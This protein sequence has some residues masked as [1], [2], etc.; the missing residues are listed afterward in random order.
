MQTTNPIDAALNDEDLRALAGNGSLNAN[1]LHRAR[2]L[3]GIT[4]NAGQWHTFLQ[5]L[6]VVG[7]AAVAS[8]ALICFIAY[9]WNALGRWFRFGLIEGL[10]VIA[11]VVALMAGRRT[12]IAHAA[13]LIAFFALGGLLA[14]TGQTYQTGADTWQL[15]AGWA[16]LGLLW[17]FAARWWGLWLVWLLVV[18]MGLNI[19]AFG[20]ARL[21]RWLTRNDEPA[22]FLCLVNAVIFAAFFW[23]RRFDVLNVPWVWRVAAAFTIFWAT[24]SGCVGAWGERIDPSTAL[25]VLTGAAVLAAMWWWTS[26]PGT[27]EF[28]PWLL[29]LVGFGAVIVSAHWLTRL[30]VSLSWELGSLVAVYVVGAAVF[31]HNV[32]RNKTQQHVATSASAVE[33]I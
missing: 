18:E 22:L 1:T 6:A 28:E 30:V 7:G 27:A 9:N 13:A 24:A 15:F 5:R 25:Y 32:I 21:G 19:W 3:L 20:D 16:A 31:L 17:V 23:A 4:P 2:E 29:Y 14:F 11:V 26:R 12:S 33:V 8:S 10:M